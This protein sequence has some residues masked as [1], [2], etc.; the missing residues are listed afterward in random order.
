[1]WRD[2]GSRRRIGQYHD[3]I[4]FQIGRTQV[5]RAHRFDG[6]GD[7]LPIGADV[8]CGRAADAAGNAAQ[9][10]DACAILVTAWATKSSQLTPAPTLKST[11]LPAES[12]T[13]GAAIPPMAIFSTS[14]GQPESAMTRLLPPPR[15]NKGSLRAFAIARA[16]ANVVFALQFRKVARHSAHL[17]GGQWRERNV[18]LN[19]HEADVAL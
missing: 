12:C 16:S 11:P 1:M 17:Q 2:N 5:E 15:T 9:A 7:L 14:P 13:F 4:F 8:L 3:A 6:V 18:F 10:L 19:R